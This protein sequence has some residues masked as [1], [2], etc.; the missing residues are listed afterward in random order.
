MRNATSPWSGLAY[1]QVNERT[2]RIKDSARERHGLF[3]CGAFGAACVAVH[4]SNIREWHPPARIAAQQS[5]R[6]FGSAFL[7]PIRICLTLCDPFATYRRIS[8]SVPSTICRCI[9]VRRAAAI[10]CPSVLTPC[11]GKESPGA[12][13]LHLA[14]HDWRLGPAVHRLEHLEECINCRTE[15]K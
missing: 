10:S 2:A 6:L 14:L 1:A 15:P 13:S 7:G 8:H 4:R 5:I 9:T 3:R 12:G 11:K